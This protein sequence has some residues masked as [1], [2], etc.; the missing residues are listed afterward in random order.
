MAKCELNH[1]NGDQLQ[2]TQPRQLAGAVRSEYFDESDPKGR[3]GE[4]EVL[5][6]IRR[7]NPGSVCSSPTA[8]G[9]KLLSGQPYLAGGENL[10]LDPSSGLVCFSAF[11]SDRRCNDYKVRFCCPDTIGKCEHGH[12]WTKWQDKKWRYGDDETFKKSMTMAYAAFVS[13]RDSCI[14]DQ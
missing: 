13:N 7:K 9:A 2:G 3:F 10:Q 11:Q 14:V 6:E 1:Y 4:F 8:V 5:S 12:K